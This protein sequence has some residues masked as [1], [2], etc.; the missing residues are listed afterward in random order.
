MTPFALAN[1][2]DKSAV[3]VVVDQ[4]ILQSSTLAF[5]AFSATDS[6]FIKSSALKAFLDAT[7]PDHSVLD[8]ANLS[9]PAAAAAPAPLKK[10]NSK[11]EKADGGEKDII[12]GMTVKK[13]ENFPKWYEQVLVRRFLLIIPWT[14]SHQQLTTHSIP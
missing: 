8:F 4:N 2:N 7:V 3:T 9:A 10:E 14:N 13:E 11:T 1:V 5:R 6:M 12:I